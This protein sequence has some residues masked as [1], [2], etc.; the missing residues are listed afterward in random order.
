M[1]M[2]CKSPLSMRKAN[3]HRLLARRPSFEQGEIG[4]DL[5]RKAWSSGWKDWSA[6]IGNEPTRQV[7]AARCGKHGAD[8][9]LDLTERT[10]NVRDHSLSLVKRAKRY[11][12]SR[13]N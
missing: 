6:S 7:V 2:T 10:Q 4:P 3:L 1:A 11:P 5:F 8:V 12:V 13:G 9:K